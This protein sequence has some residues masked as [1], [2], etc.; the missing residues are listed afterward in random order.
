MTMRPRYQAAPA[1]KLPMPIYLVLLTHPS[2]FLR[3]E[4]GLA[5]VCHRHSRPFEFAS[6]VVWG[7]GDGDWL[8]ISVLVL[9][10]QQGRVIR[11]AGLTPRLP[12]RI[13]GHFDVHLLTMFKYGH[14]LALCWDAMSSNSKNHCR[15]TIQTNEC[16][17][18]TEP[19]G[20]LFH[21]LQKEIFVLHQAFAAIMPAVKVD[22]G[23]AERFQEL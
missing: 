6:T 19:A 3:N 20:Q 23:G 18:G 17:H 13:T 2:L 12:A 22:L 4:H 11:G 16:D 14:L 9:S 21:R 8:Q 5:G 10:F 7:G 1:V 15:L